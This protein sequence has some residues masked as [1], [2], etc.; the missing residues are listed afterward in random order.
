M[1][2]T[3]PPPPNAVDAAAGVVGFDYSVVVDYEAEEA[4][5]MDRRCRQPQAL[6]S[7]VYTSGSTSTPITIQC[8][9]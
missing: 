8:S 9:Y 1:P 5:V 3:T 7:W 6:R 4:A 2:P